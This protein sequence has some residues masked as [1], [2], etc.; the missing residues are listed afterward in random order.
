MTCLGHMNMTYE[1]HIHMTVIGVG[2]ICSLCWSSTMTWWLLGRPTMYV[3]TTPGLPERQ[4]L[5]PLSP[6]ISP[7]PP[8]CS[9]P[10]LSRPLPASPSLSRSSGWQVVDI[11]DKPITRLVVYHDATNIKISHDLN[12]GGFLY[13]RSP[14]HFTETILF[15][16]YQKHGNLKVILIKVLLIGTCFDL[17]YRFTWG[18]CRYPRHIGTQTV[19]HRDSNCGQWPLPSQLGHGMGSRCNQI[20]EKSQGFGLNLV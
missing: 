6:H 5:L 4:Q 7:P 13:Q 12:S 1:W 15:S 16:G 10:G 11:H 9:S 8:L 18:S 14:T 3:Y 17:R 20:R 2:V 19:A